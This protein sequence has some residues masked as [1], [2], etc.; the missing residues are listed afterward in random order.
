MV[1]VAEH[2][3]L[4]A[5]P[6]GWFPRLTNLFAW[7]GVIALLV[8]TLLV[9]ADIV[10][11]RVV[12]GAFIDVFDIGQLALVAVASWSIPYGFV[13]GN[14]VSVDLLIERLPVAGRAWGDLLIHAVCALLFALLTWFAWGALHL[15]Q[16]YGDTTQNLGLPVIWYWLVFL[17][18]MLLTI[19]ACCWRVARAWQRLRRGAAA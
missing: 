6:A 14:H 15:H 16:S 9:C 3:A 5:E 10:W 7:L 17:I 4:P 18:G 12:G 13:H 1:A 2:D 11:R 8:P 19:A